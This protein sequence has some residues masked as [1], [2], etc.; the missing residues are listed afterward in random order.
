M[1][2]LVKLDIDII[3]VLTFLSNQFIPFERERERQRRKRER[4]SETIMCHFNNNPS[5]VYVCGHGYQVIREK[6]H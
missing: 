5:S 1:F 6:L 3:Y 4:E 2:E